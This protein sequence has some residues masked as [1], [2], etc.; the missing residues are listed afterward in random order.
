[1]SKSDAGATASAALFHLGREDYWASVRGGDEPPDGLS[2][3]EIK[4]WKAGWVAGFD[5]E[6]GTVAQNV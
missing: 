6:W 5:E 3:D 1:M 2:P 4:E